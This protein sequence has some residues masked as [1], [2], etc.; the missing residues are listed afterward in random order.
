MYAAFQYAGNSEAWLTFSSGG[1]K[2]NVQ[3]PVPMD[4]IGVTVNLNSIN[5]SQTL[6]AVPAI[7]FT[8]EHSGIEPTRYAKALARVERR[9]RTLLLMDSH[10]M[11]GPED[12]ENMD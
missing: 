11:I 1:G 10:I 7:V 9:L 12:L 3:G 4:R 2:G 6:R 5:E 8:G